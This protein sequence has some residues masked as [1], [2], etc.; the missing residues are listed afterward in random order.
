M[1]K[2][3]M[4][5]LIQILVTYIMER[6]PEHEVRLT[7]EEWEKHQLVPVNWSWGMNPA[8]E[9]FFKIDSTAKFDS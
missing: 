4:E 1:D 9:V 6:V 2:D 8:G 5:M 7:K 3:E